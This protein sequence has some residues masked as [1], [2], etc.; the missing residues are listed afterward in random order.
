MIRRSAVPLADAARVFAAARRT[1][2]I[3]AAL[4]AALAGLLLAAFLVA[5]G[6]HE[7]VPA[8]D[9]ASG[10]FV[11]VI[12]VS[13]SVSATGYRMIGRTLQ[14]IVRTRRDRPTGVVVFADVAAEALPPGTSTREL[15][16]FLRFYEPPDPTASLAY[17]NLEKP[18]RTG[19]GGGTRISNGLRVAREALERDANGR[20]SVLLLSDLSTAEPDVAAL[21]AELRTYA[22]TPS[23]ELRAAPLPLA[24]EEDERFFE[25][26]I[27]AEVRVPE[28]TPGEEPGRPGAVPERVPTG[29]VVLAVLVGLALALNELFAVPLAWRRVTEG[30]RA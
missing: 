20:G 8:L 5:R 28:A 2:V 12:D 23:L 15:A 18:W 11:V 25:R 7:P 14:E 26:F 3:R 16:R 21:E 30:S 4:A 27:G 13:G 19:L 29:L 9:P 10:G 22:R 6:A 1:R 24:A 17:F